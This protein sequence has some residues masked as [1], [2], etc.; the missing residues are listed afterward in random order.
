M[1]ANSPSD[2]VNGPFGPGRQNAP[3]AWTLNGQPLAEG[4]IPVAEMRVPLLLTAGGDDQ[5]W[6]SAIY[7]RN[8]VVRLDATPGA[9]PRT[10]AP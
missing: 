2:A 10:Y 9:P 7:V 8:V 3:S 4:P 6:P 5:I 1:I